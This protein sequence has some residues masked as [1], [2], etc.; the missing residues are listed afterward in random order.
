MLLWHG[1]DVHRLL[2]I[3]VVE[4]NGVLVLSNLAARN[5]SRNNLAKNAV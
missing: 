1:K 3:D 4:S 2:W 5:L